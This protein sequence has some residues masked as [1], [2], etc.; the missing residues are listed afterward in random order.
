MEPTEDPNWK[1]G[2]KTPSPDNM[3]LSA[4]HNLLS[5]NS[6]ASMG[7]QNHKGI[8]EADFDAAFVG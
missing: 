2:S 8:S 3:L 4:V 1:F 7:G 5:K 6:L